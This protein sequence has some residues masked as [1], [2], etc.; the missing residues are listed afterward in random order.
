MAGVGGV[1]VGGGGLRG[2]GV[3]VGE[4]ELDEGEEGEPGDEGGEEDD[5]EDEAELGVDEEGGGGGGVGAGL[6]KAIVGVQLD[7][8]QVVKV[9]LVVVVG[10]R[11]LV[12]RRIRVLCVFK[13]WMR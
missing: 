4:A 5:G 1:A 7:V 10:V 9:D 12:A 2:L 13:Q 3:V 6:G 11:E 8:I